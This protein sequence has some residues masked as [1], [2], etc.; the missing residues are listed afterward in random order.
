MDTLH[1]AQRKRPRRL[2]TALAAFA[3]VAVL[4]PGTSARAA[5]ALGDTA[6]ATLTWGAWQ[7]PSSGS[8]TADITTAAVTSGTGTLL[9]GT[10]VAG[11]FTITANPQC[12]GTLAITLSDAGGASGVTLSNFHL[13]VGGTAIANG[14]TVALPGASY[15]KTLTVGATATYTSAVATGLAHPTFNIHMLE[16]GSSKTNDLNGATSNITF[17][18]PITFNKT[19]DID[20]GTVAALTASTYR[21]ST[22]GATSVVSG[23][24]SFYS[25]SPHAASITVIG[26][27]SD[28][29]TI[30]ATGYTAN[31]GVT[32]SSATCAYNGGAETA[33]SSAFTGVAPGA[34][35]TLLVGV[36]VAADGTQAGTTTAAP[37]FTINVN[38]Q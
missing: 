27:T 35:Q 30:Q 31:N 10:P 3:L 16:S 12:T 25:G 17:D 21:I 18:V 13:N 14:G 29:I 4:L 7:K 11:T 2:R 6:V 5:C 24:G 9:Y 8:Q 34:G 38:Y 23:S 28:G 37:T 15:S 20:F 26:S 22:T 33:C 36:D 32:P 19:A 1:S